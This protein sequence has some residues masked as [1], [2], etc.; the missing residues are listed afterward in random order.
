MGEGSWD[1]TGRELPSVGVLVVEGP[2][3]KFRGRFGDLKSDREVQEVSSRVETFKTSARV[4]VSTCWGGV[5]ETLR[6]TMVVY[7]G[8]GGPSK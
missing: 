6:V 4:Y 7:T 1:L 2:D 8:D 5:R 3:R